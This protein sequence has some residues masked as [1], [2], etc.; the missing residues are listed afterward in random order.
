MIERSRIGFRPSSASNNIGDPVARSSGFR[1][2]AA[3]GED[4]DGRIVGLEQSAEYH[5]STLGRRRVAH[6]RAAFRGLASDGRIQGFVVRRGDY[7]KSALKMLFP[8]SFSQPASP[9]R[10]DLLRQL[11]GDGRRDNGY[12][13]AGPGKR[14]SLPRSHASAADD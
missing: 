11:P 2:I 9:P 10:L 12:V 14:Q 3:I 4:C 8:V 1:R 5:L 6:Q 7:E 13:G